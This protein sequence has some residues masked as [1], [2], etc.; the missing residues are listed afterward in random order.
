MKVSVR[1]WTSFA[2]AQGRISEIRVQI[3][4]VN[5]PSMQILKNNKKNFFFNKKE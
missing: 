3:L 5:R 1:S 2:A 4:T